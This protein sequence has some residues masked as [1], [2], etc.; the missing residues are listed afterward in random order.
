MVL[1]KILELPEQAH[2][3][4]ELEN[5]SRYVLLKSK[6]IKN[7]KLISIIKFIS[8]FFKSIATM[9]EL[10]FLKFLNMLVLCYEPLKTNNKNINT[11]YISN[12]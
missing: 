6:N 2:L 1:T 12:N 9:L 4:L 3:I 8:F 7:K 5:Q 10:W 11:I